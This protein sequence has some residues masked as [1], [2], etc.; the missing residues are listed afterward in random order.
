NDGKLIARRGGT[1]LAY[2][3]KAL[4]PESELA[5]QGNRY[6]V[7]QIGIKS[8]IGRLYEVGREDVQY[9]ECDVQYLEDVAVNGRNCTVIQ[10]THPVRRTNFQY[11]MA[12]I[13]LDNELQV[14]I[15]FAAYDWPSG[16]DDRPVLLE[17]Y[18]YIDLKL[19]LGLTDWDF[20]TRNEEYGFGRE[21]DQE[22]LAIDSQ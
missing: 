10:V 7:T 12:R 19:N 21:V 11:H 2:F 20:D 4:D 17:E 9:G 1:R 18:T 15:R 5:M 6:P 3:T 14:P 16:G 22:R 8:L 13:F